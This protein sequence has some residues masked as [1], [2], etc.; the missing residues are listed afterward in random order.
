MV[1]VVGVERADHADVVD[2][3]ADLGVKLRDLDARLAVALEPERRGHHLPALP[4]AGLD[5][6]G[7][8]L[9]LVVLQGGL[10]VERIDVRR[11]AVHEQEDQALG[12]RREVRRVRRQRV[13]RDGRLLGPRRGG[14]EPGVGEDA[15]Q[16]EGAEAAPDAGE[17]V[18]TGQR[19]AE[20]GSHGGLRRLGRWG[21][22]VSQCRQIRSCRAGPGRI[23]PSARG[24]RPSRR[25][26]PGRRRGRVGSRSRSA[27]DRRAG[28]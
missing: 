24:R 23:A 7:R 27:R 18:A 26:A 9:P 21:Q 14:E 28:A 17:Q 22:S 10:G 20:R 12:P 16:A 15:G 2:A 6:I 11:P 13:E 1:R 4:A 19:R 5:R 3:A 8:V 25:R